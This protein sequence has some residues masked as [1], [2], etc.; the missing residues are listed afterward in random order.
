M[1]VR[2][3]AGEAGTW[4]VG[5]RD[6]AA[7]QRLSA[8]LGVSRP[9]AA[10]LINRGLADPAKA[11]EFLHC[12]LDA[13]HDPRLLPDIADAVRRI[14]AA[15]RAGERI[16][17]HGD[18]DADGVTAVAVLLPLLSDLGASV[19]YFVPDR[20]HGEYGLSASTV[21]WAASERV[22]LIITV[23]C[24]PIDASVVREA[25]QR[26]VDLI[27]T[28]HHPVLDGSWLMPGA[29]ER[30]GRQL[31][32]LGDASEA[33]ERRIPVVNPTRPDSTY[34]NRALSGVGVAY[35]LGAALLQ[36]LGEPTEA[37]LRGFLDLVAVGTI[38]DV[39][40]L[41]GENRVLARLGLELLPRTDRIGLRALADLCGIGAKPDADAVGFR[42][43]PRLNAAGR[44]QHAREAVELL[45]TDDPRLAARYAASL[46]R[47]NR[48]R[49]DEQN[50]V[51][52]Q[53]QARLGEEVDLDA[54]RAIVLASE[55]WHVGVLGIAA[56]K[57]VDM[58]Q[59]PTILLNVQDGRA[60][61]SARSIPGFNIA[62][63]LHECRDHL[64]R[65]GGH[66][67]AAGLTLQPE[68]VPAFQA[69]FCALA[70]EAI[71]DADVAPSL[72]V[73]CEVTL[74]ELTLDLADEIGRLQ[75][76]G[77]GNRPPVLAA[78]RLLVR[79]SRS[80]GTS[81]AHLKL[82]VTDLPAGQAG[83]ERV[84]DCIGF[85]LGHWAAKVRPGQTIDAC[86]TPQ[87]DEWGGSRS[88]QLRL[89]D[90]RLTAGG[91]RHKAGGGGQD[92]GGRR[93]DT[94]GR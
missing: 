86:F 9:T 41:T 80:I 62:K 81:G 63:A 90:I 30:P 83:E 7:E 47:L 52:A 54:T 88:V 40:P 78:H 84:V 23:D 57:L 20:L 82:A 76:F 8:V 19:G 36:E 4:H 43:G 93:R 2:R 77:V 58:H 33:P 49:Q 79:A 92:T 70:N 26:G 28:D 74:P 65:Y 68:S 1:P 34:P 18:Y 69:A 50:R 29:P 25:Q 24:R 16:L 71:G 64:L 67:L 60:R 10:I 46:D 21:A 11:Q 48:D 39:A 32:L 42:I 22:R 6:P 55:G 87:I 85:D 89:V 15:L 94:G 66:P 73:D 27:V 5:A 44:M 17:V 61:G 35:K 37:Y 45:L 31:S 3:Q 51:V 91:S 13:L 14:V 53:A 59:R 12:S 38:A 72:D 75:P 56:S